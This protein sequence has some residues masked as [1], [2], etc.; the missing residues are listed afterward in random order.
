[1]TATVPNPESKKSRPMFP[2]TMTAVLGGLIAVPVYALT[3]SAPEEAPVLADAGSAK[4]ATANETTADDGKDKREAGPTS[5]EAMPPGGWTTARDGM[6][7]AAAA[8]PAPPPGMAKS[9][10]RAHRVKGGMAGEGLVAMD[11]PA[12][13]AW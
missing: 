11:A 2:L 13:S 3:L 6:D 12:A 8:A 1:M 4:P 10:G 7:A 5:S 9:S